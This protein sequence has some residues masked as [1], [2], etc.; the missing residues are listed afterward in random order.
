MVGASSLAL[1]EKKYCLLVEQDGQSSKV[2]NARTV[3]VCTVSL[4]TIA[5]VLLSQ[6]T[7]ANFSA[8]SDKHDSRCVHNVN[9][10]LVLAVWVVERS[11][12]SLADTLSFPLSHVDDAIC[13]PDSS[14]HADVL[15]YGIAA[16]SAILTIETVH[17]WQS[18]RGANLAQV[19]SVG[20]CMCSVAT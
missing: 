1:P 12:A 11:A 10:V 18:T 6:L 7:L 20:H 2:D 3:Q 17:R 5:L 19:G 9:E 4:A 13:S 15:I 14:R 8:D 16:L